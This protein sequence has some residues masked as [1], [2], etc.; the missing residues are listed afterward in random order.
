MD[1]LWKAIVGG[2]LTAVIAWAAKRGTVLPGLLPL[3]P[4]LGLIALFIV[5][6][7]GDTRAFQQV[8]LSGLKT[9]PAYAVFLIGCYSVAGRV[10]F[11]LALAIG[12]AAWLAAAGVAFLG[13][14]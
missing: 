6:A 2:L 11:R 8:C 4:T 7:R 3:F 5:G 10:D 14:R 12:L 1:I 9:V 13:T